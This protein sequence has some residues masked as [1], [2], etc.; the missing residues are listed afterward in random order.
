M[1]M[2]FRTLRAQTEVILETLDHRYLNDL[3]LFQGRNPSS[4]NL[5]AYIFAELSRKVDRGSR[6]LSRVS[7][8][9]SANSQATYHR[10]EK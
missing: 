2:D 10:P 8:W 5:A 9:E 6:R 3:P 7:V 1:V 4:E